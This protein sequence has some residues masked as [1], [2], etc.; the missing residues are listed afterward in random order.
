[1]NCKLKNIW[2]QISQG[3]KNGSWKN[4]FKSK[5]E[6]DNDEKQKWKLSNLNTGFLNS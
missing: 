3:K 1:M 6:S 5:W 4:N 2:T